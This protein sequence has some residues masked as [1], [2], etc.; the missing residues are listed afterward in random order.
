MESERFR[1]I[2]EITNMIEK[3]EGK[4]AEKN[5]GKKKTKTE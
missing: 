5:E 1:V 3:N 4:K 2:R